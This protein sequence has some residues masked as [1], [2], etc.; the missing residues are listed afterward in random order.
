MAMQPHRTAKAPNTEAPTTSLSLETISADSTHL[1]H[2]LE[3]FLQR[4]Q[5]Q[6]HKGPLLPFEGIRE[7]LGGAGVQGKGNH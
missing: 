1:V 2:K 4:A 3:L 6:L 7:F 5:G